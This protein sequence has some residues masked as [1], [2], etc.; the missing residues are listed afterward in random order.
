M[1][2]LICQCDG[3]SLGVRLDGLRIIVKARNHENFRE[4]YI[5]TMYFYVESNDNNTAKLS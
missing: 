4:H 2:L 3:L 5:Y 1:P